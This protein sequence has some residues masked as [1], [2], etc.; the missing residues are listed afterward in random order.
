METFEE[1]VM[2]KT[3]ALLKKIE[4]A[5]QDAKKTLAET[6][7]LKKQVDEFVDEVRTEKIAKLQERLAKKL[8]E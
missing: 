8:A 4:E 2:A 1:K 6:R 5:H 7:E 3:N